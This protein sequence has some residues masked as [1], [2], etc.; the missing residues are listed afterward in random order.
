[1][2]VRLFKTP[3]SEVLEQG[4]ETGL[5]VLAAVVV[6][7]NLTVQEAAATTRYPIP[8]CR[9]HLD[10][11]VG[12]KVLDLEAGRYRLSTHWHRSAVRALGRKNLLA[13]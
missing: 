13:D 8:I 4:G 7:E 10:R 11:F 9:L 1:M 3:Q 12:Q 5:F 6:H 2:R